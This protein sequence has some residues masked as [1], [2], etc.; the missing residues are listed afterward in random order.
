MDRVIISLNWVFGTLFLAVAVAYPTL[1]TKFLTGA[2]KAVAMNRVARIAQME[3][4]YFQSNEQYLTFAPG[5]M[6]EAFRQ[7][8]GLEAGR[9]KEFIYDAF[10]DSDGSF[11]I[12]AQA[13][14]DQVKAKVLPP[15]TYI[16]RKSVGG[17][18]PK[19]A[20]LQ[21]SG[22]EPGLL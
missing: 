9:K 8:L 5:L 10:M 3:E 21:L 19:E 11:V 6:P 14:L 13:A 20:W 16:Y 2:K 4:S 1:D 15:L 18:K 17:G 12:R 7:Q 22:K